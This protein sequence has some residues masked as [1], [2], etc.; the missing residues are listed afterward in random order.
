MKKILALLLVI[1]TILA[2]AGCDMGGEEE[3]E[4]TSKSKK[5]E[6]TQ[7]DNVEDDEAPGVTSVSTVTSGGTV[8][9]TSVDVG[10]TVMFSA[11][12]GT[13]IDG[14]YYAKVSDR[15]NVSAD[16][17]PYVQREGYTL[18]GWAYDKAGDSMWA[19]T[20]VFY[21]NDVIY[22]CWQSNDV[23]TDSS[24]TTDT[25]DTADTGA[26]VDTNVT[27]DT[28]DSSNWATDESL[29]STVDSSENVTESRDPTVDSSEWW[30]TTDTTELW[31]TDSSDWWDTDESWE[32][33]V[34][35]SEWWGTDETTVASS[36]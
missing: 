20:D 10:I 9:D 33:S 22:A 14:S 16:D 34:D 5:T 32:P 18:V 24:D 11:N 7:V 2:F 29:D 27:I 15:G 35:S 21:K 8:T 25:S 30:G 17:L 31:D 36:E 3:E 4:S 23:S 6:K 12:G 28:S 1:L 13:I 19:E 26:T